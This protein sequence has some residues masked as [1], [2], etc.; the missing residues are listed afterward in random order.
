MC[1]FYSFDPN[2][3]LMTLMLKPDLRYDRDVDLS[4][5]VPRTSTNASGHIFKYVDQKGLAAM[6]T[7]VQSAGVTPEVNVKTT[8]AKKQAKGIHPGFETQ[9]RNGGISGSR[10]GLTSS[11][12]FFKKNV[13][14]H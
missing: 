1:R 7:S 2:L 11:N 9:C 8:Q 13:Y 12:N 6:L 5:F 4:V 14:V 3:G 10:K